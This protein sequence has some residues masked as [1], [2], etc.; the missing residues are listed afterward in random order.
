MFQSTPPMQGATDI[1]GVAYKL[2]KVSIHAPYAGSDD[3][4]ITVR[5][6]IPGFNPRP[7]CRE[8][9]HLLTS[10]YVK[11]KF[12][13]TPPMQG[14]TMSLH[15]YSPVFSVSIHAPYAGSD[16][17]IPSQQKHLFVSIHAPYAGSDKFPLAVIFI[18]RKFQSTPPMQGATAISAKNSSSFSAEIDKLS[19]QILKFPLFS[20][21]L[22]LQNTPFVHI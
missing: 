21:P 8:R 15:L 3:K 4:T 2:G 12:Q 9:L 18:P 11:I 6:Q 17:C 5:I 16:I 14:A 13:S 22:R 10:A 19:F 7:L 20:S 1:L